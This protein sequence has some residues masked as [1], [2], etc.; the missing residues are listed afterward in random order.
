MNGHSVGLW[1]VFFEVN[2][3]LLLRVA[4]V[5]KRIEFPGTL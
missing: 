3:I 1:F 2:D 4:M 5:L